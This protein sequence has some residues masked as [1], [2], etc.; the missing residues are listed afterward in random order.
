VDARP[1]PDAN[2]KPRLGHEQ[3]EDADQHVEELIALV[4]DYRVAQVAFDRAV[5]N[6]Q[7]ESSP[8]GKR[9][10]S[11]PTTGAGTKFLRRAC[12]ENLMRKARIHLDD[13][14]HPPMCL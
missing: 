13:L 14:S 11:S 10:G 2:S 7:G 6:T 4:G 12:Y 8:C 3:W 9:G 1:Q 5:R